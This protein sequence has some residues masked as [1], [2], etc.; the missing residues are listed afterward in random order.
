MKRFLLCFACA[1]VSLAADKTEKAKLP[2]SAADLAKGEKLFEAHCAR[3]H[4]PKGE[5]S[6]GPQLAVPKLRRAPDDAALLKIVDDGIRGTEMP[7]A[8][9]MTPHE[10]RQ[11]AAYVRSLGRL[12][13]K[14]VPGD[15]AGPS[16]PSLT[17]APNPADRQRDKPPTPP[18]ASRLSATEL[19]DLVAYLAS[20]KESK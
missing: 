4:G 9:S 14:P 17:P 5:G 15:P 8:N 3:C 12:P 6:R 16:S 11:T 18:A 13:S 2:T 20:L 7:G 10:Q 19:T 1:I